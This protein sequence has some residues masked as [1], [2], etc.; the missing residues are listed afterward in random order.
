MAFFLHREGFIN[1][2]S[3]KCLSIALLTSSSV[4]LAQ[5]LL[6]TN[7]R[8]NQLFSAITDPAYSSIVMLAN[9][10]LYDGDE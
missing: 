9:F 2:A 7:I 6:F 1:I 4:N 3:L 8:V 10:G 5:S